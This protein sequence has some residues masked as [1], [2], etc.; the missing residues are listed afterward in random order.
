[1]VEIGKDVKQIPN[2]TFPYSSAQREFYLDPLAHTIYG[3][4]RSGE[5]VIVGIQG[6]QGTGKTTLANYLVSRLLNEGCHVV[7][8]SIDDFYTSYDNRRCLAAQHSGNPFYQLPRGMP[9]THHTAELYDT[10]SRLKNGDDVDLPV[11]DKSAHQGYGDI[12]NRVE[13]VRGRQ[14]FV[15][16]EGWC[17]GM[18]MVTLD[19]LL[20]IC[21]RQHLQD[22]WTL[23]AAIHLDVV[24]AHL[25]AYQRLWG[26]IDFLMMLYPD[27]LL[28]HEKW[29]LEQEKDMIARTGA[30]M[31]DAQVSDM[32]RHFL[33]FTCLC[34]EKLVPDLRIHINKEHSCYKMTS[35]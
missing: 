1:M 28:L 19:E 21:H 32:F 5:T 20:A 16:I 29:R 6:G 8:V 35:P 26:M 27:T 33:P 18:P 24:L 9:G 13:A 11:F 34:Y 12:A 30:G 3:L 22:I 17:I 14:D 10:L 4:S 31:P 7:S 23:P 25:E 15:L 2:P